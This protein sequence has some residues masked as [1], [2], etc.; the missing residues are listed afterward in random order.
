MDCVFQILLLFPQINISQAISDASL[1]SL[2]F[3]SIVVPYEQQKNQ[4]D[5][6]PCGTYGWPANSF[7]ITPCRVRSNAFDSTIS[8]A[9]LHGDS[10][11]IF[12]CS[13][14]FKTHGFSNYYESG[15]KP[16][17]KVSSTHGLSPQELRI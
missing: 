16:D 10:L 12:T 11:R 5:E 3:H 1:Y 9:G 7:H 8:R 6:R 14:S 15:T 2:V 17:I 13:H 4:K